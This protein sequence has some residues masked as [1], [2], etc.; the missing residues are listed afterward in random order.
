MACFERPQEVTRSVA[1]S[2]ISALVYILEPIREPRIG[3]SGSEV[4]LALT[5]DVEMVNFVDDPSYG[6]G[7]E[8]RSL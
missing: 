7:S 6:E 1:A 4:T 8:I 2:L 3:R 5:A